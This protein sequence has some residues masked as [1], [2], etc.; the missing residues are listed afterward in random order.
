LLPPEDL[1]ARCFVRSVKAFDKVPHK[2]LISKLETYGVN[3]EIVS[4]IAAFLNNRGQRVEINVCFFFL[5]KTV[6]WSS[7]GI[8]LVFYINYNFYL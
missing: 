3:K 4:W 5:D 7:A 6:Y 1:N 2:R 8:H